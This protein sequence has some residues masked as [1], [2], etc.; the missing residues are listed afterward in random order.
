MKKAAE[1]S[2]LAWI[3][4]ACGRRVPKWVQECRC[5][6]KPGSVERT[7]IQLAPGSSSQEPN[8]FKFVGR[9][10][11]RALKAAH[12][13]S[14]SAVLGWATAL[15]LLV[16]LAIARSP[17]TESPPP[18]TPIAEQ[19][20]P[21]GPSA[22]DPPVIASSVPEDPVIDAGDGSPD[23]ET[24][25]GA[26]AA[27]S[28]EEILTGAL[29]AV[30]SV[31]A[32]GKTGGGFFAGRGLVITNH[33]VVAGSSRATIRISSGQK[34]PAA[35]SIDSNDFDTVEAILTRRACCASPRRLVASRR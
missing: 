1:P 16:V 21:S 5:G 9:A 27:P 34:F 2:R 26:P 33:H 31:E 28:L 24:V 3:C 11:A 20:P 29:P 30:V 14:P 23:P 15:C 19:E 32:A 17:K 25:P 13:L 22:S 8:S 35:V 10:A 7:Q 18:P 4:S 6:L 12:R